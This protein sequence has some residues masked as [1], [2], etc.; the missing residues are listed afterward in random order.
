MSGEFS[1]FR[2]SKLT[3]VL[4]CVAGLAAIAFYIY[5]KVLF[6]TEDLDEYGYSAR[7]FVGFLI[8]MSL[9]LLTFLF[10]WLDRP[11]GKGRC[12]TC[13][14]DLTGNVSGGCPECGTTI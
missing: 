2:R 12:R 10:A 14:Y 11:Y 5:R 7:W 8:F 13:G 9:L 6:F 1:M 4:T 3:R